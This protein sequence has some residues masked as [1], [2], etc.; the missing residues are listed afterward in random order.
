MK[1]TE[2]DIEKLFNS[3]YSKADYE[4]LFKK[5][6]LEQVFFNMVWGMA[7]KA[8]YDKS[9]RL[10]WILDHATEKNNRFILPI[11]PELYQYILKT[12]HESCIRQS[13]K[14]I[15]RCPIDE[16]YGGELLN[17]C[18]QW[19]NNPRAKISSQCLGLQFFYKVCQIYPEMSPE[20][21]AHIDDIIERAPSPGYKTW[22][23]KI[24][25][26]FRY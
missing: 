20:L 12:N 3:A 19:M 11:L 8:H 22:L 5:A 21:I 9:W 1:Y 16:E 17:L 18:T 6:E 23:L 7:K 15:I 4:F 13:M 24:K 14:L 26:E 25:K 2:E 10:L